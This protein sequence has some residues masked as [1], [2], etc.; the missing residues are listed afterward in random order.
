MTWFDELTGFAEES[1]EQVR[2]NLSV[3]GHVLQSRC[4]RENASV[5]RT[6]NAVLG[7]IAPTGPGEWV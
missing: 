7:R 2:A 4:Q 6:G 1:P 3:D 5:R